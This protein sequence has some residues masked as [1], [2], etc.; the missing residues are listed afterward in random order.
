MAGLDVK[1][2]PLAELARRRRSRVARARA[3][4]VPDAKVAYRGGMTSRW[5]DKYQNRIMGRPGP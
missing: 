2:S 5:S 1:K 4:A 3:P